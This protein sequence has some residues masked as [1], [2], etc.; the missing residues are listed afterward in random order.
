MIANV[1]HRR[2]AGFR[3]LLGQNRAG[4]RG[5]AECARAREDVGKGIA[6]G[7]DFEPLPLAWSNRDIE[8]IRIRGHTFHRSFLAPEL[9]ADDAHARAVVVG[10]LG[11][12]ACRNV[13]IAWISHLQR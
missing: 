10:N 3:C 8:V 9:A 1:V 6:R 2:G 13:L 5:V 11:D 7:L 12:R 4:F